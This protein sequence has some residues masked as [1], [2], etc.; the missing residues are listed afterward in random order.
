MHSKISLLLFTLTLFTSLT[1]ATPTKRG[2]CVGS[3]NPIFKITNFTFHKNV[4]SSPDVSPTASVTFTF[5]DIYHGFSTQCHANMD[6]DG[7]EKSPSESFDGS[8]SYEC[9]DGDAT[10]FRFWENG[11]LEMMHRWTCDSP[12]GA[13]T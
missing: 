11:T 7:G 13:P 2:Y 12:G 6:S 10:Q 8:K 3:P 4:T 9:G 5:A 1:L